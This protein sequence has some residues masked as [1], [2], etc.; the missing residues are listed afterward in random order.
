MRLNFRADRTH[1][2]FVIAVSGTLDAH[3]ADQI[4]VALADY[5]VATLDSVCLD[6]SGCVIGDQ[7]GIDALVAAN[8]TMHAAGT[9]LL[10]I[11]TRPAV[12]AT[13][14]QFATAS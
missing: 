4:P 8:R 7:A 10:L 13:D 5:N 6:L 12:R 9:E 1:D 14:R 3:S 2:Q 11:G